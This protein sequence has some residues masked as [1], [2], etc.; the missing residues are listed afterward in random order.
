MEGRCQYTELAI[1][2][3]LTTGGTP[4][5]RLGDGIEIPC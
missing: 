3:F 2:V 1:V 5:L 4:A